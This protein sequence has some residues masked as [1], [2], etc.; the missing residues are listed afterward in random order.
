MF[1]ACQ[2]LKEYAQYVALV[3]KYVENMPVE[4]AVECAVTE[5]I[6]KGILRDFLM[7]NRAEAI[8]VSIFEYN[9]EQHIKNEK[10]ISYEDGLREG[11]EQGIT[12]MI[13]DNYEEGKTKEQIIQKLVKRFDISPEAAE[14]YCQKVSK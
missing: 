9:E 10:K 12:L 14:R 2:T 13:L 8:E 3:R 1:E 5:C 7:Q 6:Q 4:E 11:I